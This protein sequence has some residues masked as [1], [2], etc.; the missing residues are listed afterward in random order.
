MKK[1]LRNLL[2]AEVGNAGKVCGACFTKN[3]KAKRNFLEM[4]CFLLQLM[5]LRSCISIKLWLIKV[6]L[7]YIPRVCNLNEFCRIF[8]QIINSF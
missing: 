4:E 2:A 6:S 5:L 3:Q 1:S 7:N 8:G